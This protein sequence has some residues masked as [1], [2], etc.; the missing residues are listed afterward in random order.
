M[1][2]CVCT[3]R[4]IFELTIPVRKYCYENIWYLEFKF[5]IVFISV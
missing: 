2:I 5:I 4:N 1:S 3:Y